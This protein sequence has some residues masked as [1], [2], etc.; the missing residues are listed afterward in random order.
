MGLQSDLL[1][2]CVNPFD[3]IDYIHFN[4]QYLEGI[5][6]CKVCGLALFPKTYFGDWRGMHG[7]KQLMGD[8]SVRK[9]CMHLEKALSIPC[10]SI[11]DQYSVENLFERIIGQLSTE[12]N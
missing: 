3:T 9:H 7:A 10:Y 6:Q 2:L 5:S 4:I 11:F 12:D 8:E 1:I